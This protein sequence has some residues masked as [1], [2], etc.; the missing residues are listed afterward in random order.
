MCSF[1]FKLFEQLVLADLV[2]MFQ[3]FVLTIH[4]LIKCHFNGLHKNLLTPVKLLRL[5]HNIH[6]ILYLKA[7]L[8]GSIIIARAMNAE[9]KKILNDLLYLSMTFNNSKKQR[10][11]K[12]VTDIAMIEE[13]KFILKELKKCLK[14]CYWTGH[15]IYRLYTIAV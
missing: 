9:I 4:K 13:I 3:R 14:D 5:V 2:K 11:R 6:Y 7:E 12:N 8:E 10:R 1:T 15:I